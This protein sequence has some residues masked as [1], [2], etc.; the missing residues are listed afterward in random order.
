MFSN[1]VLID[2]EDKKRLVKLLLEASSILG[3]YS[4]EIYDGSHTVTTMSRAKNAIR[5]AGKWCSLLHTVD[6]KA[7]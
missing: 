4:F 2:K 6:G 1:E 7:V 3:K 5:E